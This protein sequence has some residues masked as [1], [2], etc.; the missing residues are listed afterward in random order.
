[1]SC[2]GSPRHSSP[3]TGYQSIAVSDEAFPILDDSPTRTGCASGHKDGSSR[4]AAAGGDIIVARDWTREA[5]TEAGVAWGRHEGS[6]A[7]DTSSMHS[8]TTG[9]LG[10]SPTAAVF[11]PEAAE[12]VRQQVSG[13]PSVLE[14]SA[15]AAAEAAA[16]AIAALDWS[17]EVPEQQLAALLE[18]AT[19]NPLHEDSAAA[20]TGGWATASG[21]ADQPAEQRGVTGTA[22]PADSAAAVEGTASRQ[23]P[24]PAVRV[25]AA[26]IS[27]RSTAH[28][29]AS[30]LSSSMASGW[31][32]GMLEE[33]LVQLLDSAVQRPPAAL[34][35][36]DG[37]HAGNGQGQVAAEA[38]A[39]VWD[40][41]R[42]H[43]ST[44]G[45]A[46]NGDAGEQPG[47]LKDEQGADSD[48]AMMGAAAMAHECTEAASKGCG[49]G[50]GTG[51]LTDAGGPTA[52]L[53]NSGAAVHL[54][55]PEEL[56][57][58]YVL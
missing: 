21:A 43:E 53:Q 42:G 46:D 15:V 28:S 45:I 47:R 8:I 38:P 36:P 31:H 13:S 16:A 33:Q 57:N 20:S 11:S 34:C 6:Q 35:T 51:T 24:A 50:G 58:V 12:S 19:S 48:S 54:D 55:G 39:G 29:A 30:A 9:Q 5:F 37:V 25:P 52:A 4:A 2:Y 56:T 18:T 17:S 49:P 27:R 14:A 26:S 3:I 7:S 1:V 23:D 22:M 40:E 44:C 32:A 41:A 10:T